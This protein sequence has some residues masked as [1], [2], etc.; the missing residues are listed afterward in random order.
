MEI[1][2]II[3]L[4]AVF[5]LILTLFC[6]CSERQTVRLE[7]ADRAFECEMSW[8]WESIR[9]RA[10]LTM[11]DVTDTSVGRD[12]SL[13]F[14]EPASL[15]GVRAER[16]DGRER[17]S[18]GDIVFE[19]TDISGLIKI[20]D[21]FRTDGDVLGSSLVTLGGEQTNLVKLRCDGRELSVYLSPEDG[22]PVRI[23]TEICGRETQV[24]IL[25]FDMKMPRE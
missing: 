9:Y 15:C 6:G 25:R 7:Y 17:I 1:M 12:I 13:S 23:C 10:T 3:K 5:L 8:E 4:I 14:S 21:V 2:K 19:D 22:A 18:L 11:G 16:I 24:D 20:T